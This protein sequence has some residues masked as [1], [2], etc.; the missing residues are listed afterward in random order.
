MAT[1]RQTGLGAGGRDGCVIGDHVVSQLRGYLLRN[2]V[3]TAGAMVALGQA[4]FRASRGNGLIDDHIMTNARLK[5]RVVAVAADAFVQGVA[6]CTGRRNDRIFQY[7]L[8]EQ[9]I[10]ERIPRLPSQ[11]ST[12]VAQSTALFPRRITV[13]AFRIVGDSIHVLKGRRTYVW[14]FSQKNND[15]Q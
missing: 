13:Q 12:V 3:V 8:A 14:F 11:C 4:V 10:A 9:V 7:V 6:P 15:L 1:F 2:L 5:V